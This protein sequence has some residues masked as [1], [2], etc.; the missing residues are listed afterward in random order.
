[1]SRFQKLFGGLTL[2]VTL[3]VALVVTPGVARA[4]IASGEDGNIIW[5]LEDD[6]ELVISGTGDMPDYKVVPNSDVPSN[7]QWAAYSNDVTSVTVADGVTSVGDYAFSRMPNLIRADLGGDVA[8]IGEDAFSFC[9]SLSS[10]E[11]PSK[12]ESIGKDSFEGCKVLSGVNLPE[13]L[14]EIGSYSFRYCAFTE[15]S[16]PSSLEKVDYSAF[17]SCKS[18]VSVTFRGEKAPAFGRNVFFLC[19]KLTSIYVPYG[20][21]GYEEKLSGYVDKIAHVI[22]DFAVSGGVADT[23]YVYE[24]GVLTIKGTVPVKVSM[25]EMPSN[26][27]GGAGIGG[28]YVGGGLSITVSGGAV[29]ATGGVAAAGVGGG[30]LGS[31]SSITISG[32]IVTATGGDGGAGIG[33]GDGGAGSDITI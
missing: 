4:E 12:L 14:K 13:G 8:S 30:N 26:G 9:S 21:T 24:N 3:A 25:V 32:D 20:A 33:G 28:G 29:I 1:M 11:L 7:S 5:T 16:L 31:G 19:D 6:G 2:L 10:V 22:G 27:D 18:L 15:L 23:D 17:E